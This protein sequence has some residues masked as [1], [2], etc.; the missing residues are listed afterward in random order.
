MYDPAIGRFM[1]A[2]TNVP[3]PSDPQSL[4]RFTFVR[5][6]PMNRVDPSGH[7][8]WWAEATQIQSHSADWWNARG[9]FWNGNGIQ[10]DINRDAVFA[11][12]EILFKFLQ[13]AGFSTAGL[14]F[15]QGEI[16]VGQTIA[17]IA[18]LLGG[19]EGTARLRELLPG[20]ERP[21]IKIITGPGK[22]PNGGSADGTGG[23]EGITVSFQTQEGRIQDFYSA[24][25]VT[26]HE[27]AHTIDARSQSLLGSYGATLCRGYKSC[28]VVN[29]HGGSDYKSEEFAFTFSD[30]F[31]R[32][33]RYKVPS[34][35]QFEFILDYLMVKK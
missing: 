3:Q 13:D 16:V 15:G 27:L 33:N 8:D 2:D 34:D 35:R 4:I 22:R 28:S 12:K 1:S 9:Y 25:N 19:L 11:T 20:S 5:N 18:F 24:M 29:S 7:D 32:F 14:G 26:A 10:Y 30:Y 6:N 21:T 31:I 17:R 23:Q